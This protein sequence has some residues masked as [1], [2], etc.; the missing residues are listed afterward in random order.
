[1]GGGPLAFCV[2]LRK[3]ELLW[4]M[5][6][7]VL[8]QRFGFDSDCKTSRRSFLQANFCLKLRIIVG[9]FWMLCSITQLVINWSS[10]GSDHWSLIKLTVFLK[11][12]LQHPWHV[13]KAFILTCFIYK[14]EINLERF[15]NV[16]G[17]ILTYGKHLRGKYGSHLKRLNLSTF[18]NHNSLLVKFRPPA[19]LW[20][21]FLL[22]DGFI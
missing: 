19:Q 13:Q 4:R 14:C 18:S 3:C 20:A 5:F 21:A 11:L 17:T 15:G 12:S 6:A 8:L 16:E 7:A 1:M 2:L 22:V 10:L 9:S